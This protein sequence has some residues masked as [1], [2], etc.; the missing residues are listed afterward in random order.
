MRSKTTSIILFLLCIII[1][2]IILGSHFQEGLEPEE[3]A[4]LNGNIS[5]GNLV[6][7]DYVVQNYNNSVIDGNVLIDNLSQLDLYNPLVNQLVD[8]RDVKSIVSTTASTMEKLS[9]TSLLNDRVPIYT[10]A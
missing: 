5:V 2:S 7:M 9:P 6:N 8:S 1:L 3:A 10:K 4:R